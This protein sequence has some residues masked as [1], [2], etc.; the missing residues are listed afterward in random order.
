MYKEVI[1]GREH[2][3]SLGARNHVAIRLDCVKDEAKALEA[4]ESV[5]ISAGAIRIFHADL[6]HNVQECHS[7]TRLCTQT[8][9]LIRTVENIDNLNDEMRFEVQFSRYFSRISSHNLAR[10]SEG[11]SPH[12]PS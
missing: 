12:T 1:V 5:E 6:V 7:I 4:T 9:K 3:F 10:H 11:L 2:R 8:R